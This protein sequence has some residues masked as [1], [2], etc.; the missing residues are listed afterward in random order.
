MAQG[1]FVR[2]GLAA[3]EAEAELMCNLLREEGIEAVERQTNYGMGA[4]TGPAG[5]REI[6]VP[7][8]HLERAQELLEG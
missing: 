4:V 7:G 3:N 6:L 8:E 2:A 1:E 5:E